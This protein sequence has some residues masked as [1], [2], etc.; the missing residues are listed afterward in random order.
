MITVGIPNLKSVEAAVRKAAED[1][2][3]IHRESSLEDIAREII[4]RADTLKADCEAFLAS[5]KAKPTP[6]LTPDPITIEQV[7]QYLA[8]LGAKFD[9][10]DPGPREV[11][12]CYDLIKMYDAEAIFGTFR[13]L[14]NSPDSHGNFSTEQFCFAIAQYQRRLYAARKQ[15]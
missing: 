1:Y 5:V 9:F 8:I 13:D 10:Y 2:N 6:T 4:Q 12:R 7:E 11:K 3:N 15:L 14:I